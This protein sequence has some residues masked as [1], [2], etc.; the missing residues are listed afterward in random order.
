M[1]IHFLG[2]NGWFNTA[3]GMTSCVLIDAV[4]A[5][6]IFDAGNGFAKADQ[7][8]TDSNKP[9]VLFLSHFHLDH[10][11]GLHVLPK[12]R[13][14]QGITI[15]GQPGT[16][17]Y[18]SQLI[19]SPWTCPIDKLKTVV[20][21]VECEAGVHTQPI[22]FT[23]EFLVHADPCLG[24]RVTLEKKIVTY[25]TDTG[26]CD[27][28]TTLGTHADLFITECAW[29]VQNQ[30]PGWPHLAPEDAANAAAQADAKQLALMHFDAEQYPTFNDRNDA[31]ARAQ[32]IFPSTIGTTDDL[33]LTL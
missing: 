16:K 32:K 6:V 4:E 24:F 9:I 30:L 5:Y 25:C 19:A 18:L 2:T 17:K 31:V 12:F 23:C 21:I 29:R 13:C 8:L 7:L 28:L 27:A 15:C 14:P 3:T 22:P 1:R 26:V 10:T 33:T 20:S 11:F